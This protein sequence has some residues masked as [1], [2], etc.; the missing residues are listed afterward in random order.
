MPITDVFVLPGDVLLIPVTELPAPVREKLTCKEGDLA[1]TRPHVRTPSKII[2]ANAASLLKQFQQPKTIVAAVL[3]YSQESAADPERVLEQAL[4]FL[5]N[6]I[7]SRVLLEAGSPGAE[8]IAPTLS[9]GDTFAGF[10][11]V[12]PVH[13]VD[14]TEVFQA[15]ADA[16]PDTMAALKI[17]RLG[18]GSDLSATIDREIAVLRYL[19][20]VAAPRLLDSGVHDGRPFVAME[21]I[22]GVPAPVVAGELHEALRQAANMSARDD[23]RSRLQNLVVRVAQTYADLHERGVVHSDVHANNL[24]VHETGEVTIIDFGYARLLE[25]TSPLGTVP[26]AGVGFYFEPECAVALVSGQPAP[27]SSALGEQYSV[28]AIVYQLL[29]GTTHL[30]FSLQYEEM[31]RQI[32]QS[33]P[34]DWSSLGVEPWPEMEQVVARALRRD[35]AQRFASMREFADNLQ[36][37]SQP[38]AHV[39]PREGVEAP[40]VMT[41]EEAAPPTTYSIFIDRT[42][43]RLDPT[44]AL[45]RSAIEEGTLLPTASANHGA[46]GIA[47]AVLRLACRRGDPGLLALADLWITKTI[48]DAQGEAAFYNEKLEI[49]RDTVSE[50]SLHHMPSG[51]FFVR[52]LV[53]LAMADAASAQ[54]AM[55][56]FLEAAQGETDNLDLTLGRASVLHG[57]T[58][59]IDQA[60][61]YRDIDVEPVQ[62]FGTR[63]LNTIWE[64]IDSFGPVSRSE[65]LKYLGVAH[66][67]A[68][69]L[70]STLRWCELHAL[71]SARDL[72]E[73]LPPSFMRRLHEL[74]ECAT[75]S[76]RGMLWPWFNT[77]E[78]DRN[79]TGY[80]PGWCNGNA[81]HVFLWTLAHQVLLDPRYLDLAR[82]AAWGV[83]E[84]RV[85]FNNLCCGAAGCAYAMLA[86]YRRTADETWLKHARR[87]AD[88]VATIPDIPPEHPTDVDSLYKGDIGPMV[89]LD[90][91]SDPMRARMPLFE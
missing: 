54:G 91:L 29:T 7:D 79:E 36:A 45:F 67:W 53:S 11:I 34:R 55:H 44:G 65:E 21:W 43:Q 13:V 32:A 23:A 72:H 74:A 10:E 80:M 14:D 1:I 28:G 73:L 20:G 33:D 68:G 6:L 66:G 38:S 42:L 56:G 83:V 71:M 49:T 78:K 3:D 82:K 18:G 46:A 35:P 15:R 5:K 12:S 24:L 19:D 86:L 40:P 59:L 2:G 31:L 64:R 58:L 16:M 30:D 47:Y 37:I 61:H 87:F 81:G 57:A 76:G 22:F 52:T 62:A 51:V 26:R 9:P 85:H 90:D 17:A 4:P 60:R 41:K 84:Q 8:Q 63:V 25:E 70:Y 48:A 69:L 89:L 88:R 50:I 77:S 75:P 27:P 39:E